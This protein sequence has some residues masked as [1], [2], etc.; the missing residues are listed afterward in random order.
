MEPVSTVLAK[1]T[2]W[3][4]ECPVPTKTPSQSAAVDNEA[5]DLDRETKRTKPLWSGEEAEVIDRSCS[6]VIDVSV[7]G[8]MAQYLVDT[9]ASASLV[10]RSFAS[11]Q[12]RHVEPVAKGLILKGVMAAPFRSLAR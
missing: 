4:R 10:P 3:R 12:E 1:T 6:L 11:H 7:G 8:Q 2:A 9:G 5:N